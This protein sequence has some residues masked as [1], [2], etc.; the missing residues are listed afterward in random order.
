MNEHTLEAFR[1]MAAP[2]FAGLVILGGM[3]MLYDLIV[4]NLVSAD[5]GLAVISSI[6]GAAVAMLFQGKTISDTAR[7]VTNGAAVAAVKRAREA[8]T[9]EV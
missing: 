2:L 6:I 3:F 5:A 9:A 1:S 7:A 4:R 8:E